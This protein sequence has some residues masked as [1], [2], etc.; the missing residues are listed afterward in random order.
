MTPR[1]E[2]VFTGR[3]YHGRYKWSLW[4]G[5]KDA[6]VLGYCFVNGKGRDYLR[7]YRLVRQHAERALRLAGIR[8]VCL[9]YK[10]GEDP[11]KK[12]F[13]ERFL[14]PMKVLAETETHIFYVREI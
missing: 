14:K 13:A 3:S 6:A 4:D 11:R 1:G 7:N 5:R 12:V 2:I 10:K 8:M 9:P